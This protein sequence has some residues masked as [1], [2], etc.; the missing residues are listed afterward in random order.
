M[1]KEH[2]K[3]TRER[4]KNRVRQYLRAIKLGY[5]PRGEFSL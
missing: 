3:T 2:P 4:N 1:S 5:S